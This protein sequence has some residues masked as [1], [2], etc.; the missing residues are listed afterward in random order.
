M[1]F[2][3]AARAVGDAVRDLT[4]RGEVRALVA[5]AVQT[6]QCTIEQLRVELVEGPTRGS[7]L[8]R[9]ALAEVIQGARSRPE[10]ELAALIRRA[11]LPQPML[12]PRLYV[13]ARFLACPDAWWPEERV[14][15]EVDS[16]EWH[17]SPESWERTQR[18]QVRMGA[19][20]IVVL[21]F[22]PRR[23]REEPGEVIASI[24]ATLAQRRGYSGPGAGV[25]IRTVPAA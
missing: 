7:A 25:A 18:R 16:R 3:F 17:L 12:N 5:A 9:T 2:V 20:G 6:R 13:G 10:A 14:A 19:C 23:I 11:R 1:Q 24:R 15:V 4:D 22:T 8:F 21:P